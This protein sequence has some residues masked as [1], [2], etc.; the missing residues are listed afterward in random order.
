[1]GKKE[2]AKWERFGD[3]LAGGNSVPESWFGRKTLGK[4]M[5]SGIVRSV[6]YWEDSAEAEGQSSIRYWNSGEVV[7]TEKGL[8]ML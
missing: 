6:R 3:I 5:Q 7:A 2:T 4:W 1:M 8:R